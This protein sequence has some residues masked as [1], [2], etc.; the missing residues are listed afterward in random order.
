FGNRLPPRHRDHAALQFAHCPATFGAAG[1]VIFDEQTPRP[2]ELVRE[3]IAE[4][5]T[6][7]G[8]RAAG[9]EFLPDPIPRGGE[10]G[11]KLCRRSRS[12]NTID[13]SF[14]PVVRSSKPV[15]AS[16]ALLRSKSIDAFVDARRRYRSGDHIGSS[17]TP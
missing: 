12:F 15:S 2:A 6:K 3:V 4:L 17:V 5:R 1:Q 9:C 11:F 8:A 10:L 13:S 14:D 16:V 7:L